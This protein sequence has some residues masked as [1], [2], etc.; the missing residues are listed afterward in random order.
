[1]ADNPS[2][3]D[4][5]VAEF[6]SSLTKAEQADLEDDPNKRAAEAMTLKAILASLTGDASRA[7]KSFVG[8]QSTTNSS[9]TSV[10]INPSSNGV[11]KSA[12]DIVVQNVGSETF[13]VNTSDNT[14][15]EKL[16]PGQS[17]SFD[18]HDPADGALQ[19]YPDT[20]SGHTAE[21]VFYE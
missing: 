12:C 16:K 15:G 20:S 21:M 5:T 11:S 9:Q 1:M 2:R 17:L 3:G 19:I 13:W 8:T 4:D 7:A 14:Q 6:P 18:V 10:D